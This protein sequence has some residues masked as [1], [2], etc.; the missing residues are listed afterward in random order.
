MP[1]S[2]RDILI[3]DTSPPSLD[4][5]AVWSDGGKGSR[6]VFGS[7]DWKHLRMGLA[8]LSESLQWV[9]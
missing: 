7:W 3:Y 1:V 2:V 6:P 4:T 9:P 5:L 8:P